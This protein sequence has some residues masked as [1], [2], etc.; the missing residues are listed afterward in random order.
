MVSHLGLE[1]PEITQSEEAALWQ[2]PTDE[3]ILIKLAYEIAGNTIINMTP[4]QLE[5]LTV[6]ALQQWNTMPIT[7]LEAELIL[8]EH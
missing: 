6:Q 3:P 8:G 2:L 7:E 5:S 1:L 4:I